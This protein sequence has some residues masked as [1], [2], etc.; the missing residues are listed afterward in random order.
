M[1]L[2]RRRRGE[3]E[4]DAKMTYFGKVE[5]GGALA[6]SRGEEGGIT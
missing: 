4:G 1:E 3:E 6:A 2:E 5:G